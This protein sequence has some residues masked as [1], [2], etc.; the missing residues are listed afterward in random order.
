MEIQEYR[1]SLMYEIFIRRAFK[2]G[3]GHRRI[4][5]WEDDIEKVKKKV[6]SAIDKFL[7]RNINKQEREGLLRLKSRLDKTYKKN[8]LIVLILEA[9]D[10]TQRLKEYIPK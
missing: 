1:N 7:T 8:E 3:Q 2:Y 6:E 4:G 5:Y 9:L 10:I